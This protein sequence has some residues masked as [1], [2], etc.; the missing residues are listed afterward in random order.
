MAWLVE[1]FIQPKHP[2]YPCEVWWSAFEALEAY[3]NRLRDRCAIPEMEGKGVRVFFT[4]SAFVSRTDSSAWDEVGFD[5]KRLREL[6]DQAL[7]DPGK[8]PT[9]RL[10]VQTPNTSFKSG[11]PYVHTTVELRSV[12]IKGTPPDP[13][14]A[15]EE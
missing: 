4:A 11:K 3:L 6:C 2:A 5:A 7:S 13:K 10:M 12:K 8:T 1:A 9:L 14:G 15:C